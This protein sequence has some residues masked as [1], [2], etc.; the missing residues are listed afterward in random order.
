MKKTV[1][2]FFALLVVLGVV[3]AVAG[4]GI[5]ALWNGI[6]SAACGFAAIGFWQGVGLFLLGQLLSGGFLL[7]L[8]L[9]GGCIR[10]I[11]HPRAD[12]RGHWHNM[13][14]EQRREFIERRHREHFGFRSRATQAEEEHAAE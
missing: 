2:T 4:W 3:P 10:A 7:G 14:D 8:F 13:T 1:K 9:I 5:T 6:L 12:W 11:G